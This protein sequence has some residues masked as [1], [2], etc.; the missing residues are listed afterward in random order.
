MKAATYN[1]RSP[2]GRKIGMSVNG[3]ARS[4]S[5][6]VRRRESCGES[7][8]QGPHFGLSTT[9]RRCIEPSSMQAAS[10]QRPSWVDFTINTSEF[11]F[12][13]Q[14]GCFSTVMHLIL[15]RLGIILLHKAT[16][17]RT[18]T[19]YWNVGHQNKFMTIDCSGTTW[20]LI[21][22]SHSINRLIH[23]TVG[24]HVSFCLSQ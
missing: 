2:V 11:K 15:A 19:P 24:R 13:V 10:Y 18:F 17:S 14:T 6:P 4:R 22:L 20:V 1:A 7:A 3:M 23:F 8:A 16:I 21:Q 5:C 12:S 9:M